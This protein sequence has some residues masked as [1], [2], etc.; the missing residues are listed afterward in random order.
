[1]VFYSFFFM[2]TLL[3]YF[4]FLYSANDRFFGLEPFYC[5][6][7]CINYTSKQMAEAKKGE[8]NQATVK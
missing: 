2:I 4:Y 3:V 8:R 6:L 5:S 7:V 1:M